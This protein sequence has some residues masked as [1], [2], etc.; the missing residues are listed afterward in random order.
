M[1]RGGSLKQSRF[2]NTKTKNCVTLPEI[3]GRYMN[4]KEKNNSKYRGPPP[5][6]RSENELLGKSRAH[7]VLGKLQTQVPQINI[8]PSVDQLIWEGGEPKVFE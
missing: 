6:W 3:S 5:K 2:E 7:K 4:V 1:D 8:G